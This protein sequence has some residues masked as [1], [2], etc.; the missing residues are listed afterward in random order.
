MSE[1]PL[2]RFAV[3]GHPNKGKSSIVATLA[4]NDG[5]AIALEPGTTRENGHYPLRVDDR[6]LYELIDTP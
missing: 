2:P 4:Q 5:I 1:R 6:L 3:V